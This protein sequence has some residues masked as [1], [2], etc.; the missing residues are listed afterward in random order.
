MPKKSV[1]IEIEGQD[2]QKAAKELAE[3]IRSEFGE[4]PLRTLPDH[5][6]LGNNSGKKVDPAMVGA[7]AAAACVVL[8][9]PSALVAAMDLKDRLAKKTRVE[10]LIARGRSLKEDKQVATIRFR[11]GSAE[12]SFEKASYAKVADEVE[13]LTKE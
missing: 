13:R 4:K 5:G 8:A 7:V 9:I 6:I 12:I 11:I 1:F 10:H 2:A 3:L